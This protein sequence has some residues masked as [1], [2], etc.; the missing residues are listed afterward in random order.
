V[1]GEY[2]HLPEPAFYNVGNIE[3]AV[4]KAEALAA[5]A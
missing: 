5:E 3:D 1:D 2:D 4:R